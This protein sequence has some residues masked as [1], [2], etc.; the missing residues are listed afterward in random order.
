MKKDPPWLEML[1]EEVFLRETQQW[2]FRSEHIYETICR[3]CRRCGRHVYSVINPYGGSRGRYI[4]DVD[5]M[6][7]GPRCV[8]AS[9]PRLR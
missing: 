6:A 3:V 2:L 7:H 9:H 8:G 4:V 1:K 5:H